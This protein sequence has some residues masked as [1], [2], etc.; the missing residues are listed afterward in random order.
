MVSFDELIRYKNRLENGGRGRFN[1]IGFTNYSNWRPT[2]SCALCHVIL[3]RRRNLETGEEMP[4]LMCPR[5][6]SPYTENEA[7]TEEGIK[8]KF[9]GKQETRI[10][11]AKNK[12][13][14]YYDQS[15]NI[16][17][18]PDLIAEIQKGA[19]VISYHEELPADSNQQAFKR[20]IRK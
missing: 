16:I 10:I 8:G 19:N 6:G 20:K 15:G 4:G 3:I 14:K 7:P 17:N 5:C 11:S 1:I 2:K 13:K 18:D 12:N 9:S